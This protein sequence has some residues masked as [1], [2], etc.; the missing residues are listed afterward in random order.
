MKILLTNDDGVHAAG[1]A[2]MYDA[3]IDYDGHFGRP[4]AQSVYPIAPQTVQSAASHGI[5]FHDP[6][7][8]TPAQVNERMSGIAV[9]GRPADCVKLAL[10]SLWPE[11]FGAGARPDLVISGMNMG[12][13]AGINVI[14]SGT[15]AAAI[16]AA[17]LGVPSIA[18]SLHLGRGTARYDVAARH[19]RR[20]IERILAAGLPAA[21]SVLS[22]NVPI[23]E[24][25]GPMPPV[26]VAPMNT[27]SH[28]DSYD[29]RVSPSGRV[30][31]WSDGGSL[32]FHATTP[33]SD[34]ELLH[35]RTITVTPLKYD[36]TDADSI[37]A[38]RT[39]LDGG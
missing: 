6:L 20:V 26:R 17:F 33:G 14:Y 35:R 10:T 21:H 39:R 23:T 7:M 18:V 36:L 27:H 2:A 4:L 34:V 13:N 11:R 16:E 37:G 15:V 38:W 30:Y 28:V 9:D 22:V 1:I 3:L 25:D 24:D 5:T 31:Y 29:R 12:A 8:I 19:A 32:D